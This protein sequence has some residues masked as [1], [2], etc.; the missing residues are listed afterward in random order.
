MN[1]STATLRNWQ[2]TGQRGVYGT[3]LLELA[4]TNDSIYAISAD[5]GNSSGL[6][7]F[8]RDLPDRF[9][10][11]GISEQHMIGFAAG[12]SSLGNN[13]FV[14]SFAPFLTLRAGEQ[15]RMNLSYMK[16]NVK[17]V[18]IGSGIS[19]GYLGNSHFGL[20]D[21]SIIRSLPNIPIFQ[22]SDC[23]ELYQ[24]LKYLS[25][26]DGPAY[27]RL[28]GVAPNPSIFNSEYIFSPGKIV[29]HG[30]GHDLLVLA[31]GSIVSSVLAAAGSLPDASIQVCS[32]PSL[33]PLPED[34]LETMASFSNVLIVDEHS[35]VG[36]LSSM[37]AESLL[38]AELTLSCR[39]SSVSLPAQYLTSGT[40]E[41]LLDAY[42][43]SVSSLVSKMQS[44]LG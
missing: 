33:W 16:S 21:I 13:V 19:M 6:D 43:L 30:Y 28:T 9:L 14:S 26:F 31:S 17:L 1:V 12:L 37:V 27:L 36:G 23:Y 20:E 2:R 10:N 7:R 41:H 5:L 32:L 44:F 39:I 42:G 22:P 18:S 38:G 25:G 8:K 3:S 35:A 34:L 15:V 4:R 29:Y 11:I 40:Y 24:I